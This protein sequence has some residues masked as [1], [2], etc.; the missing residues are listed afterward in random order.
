MRCIIAIAT[1]LR[2]FDMKLYGM[3]RGPRSRERMLMQRSKLTSRF[4]SGTKNRLEASQGKLKFDGGGS[5]G[6]ANQRIITLCAPCRIHPALTFEHLLCRPRIVQIIFSSWYTLAPLNINFTRNGFDD[7]SSIS[8]QSSH[9]T[10]SSFYF[11]DH[12]Q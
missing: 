10:P 7:K 3:R 6:G 8:S 9:F 1:V 2:R 5:G 4:S 11:C 12:L